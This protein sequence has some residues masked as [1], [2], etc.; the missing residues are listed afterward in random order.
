[1]FNSTLQFIKKAK[2]ITPQKYH[3]YLNNYQSYIE[4]RISTMTVIK[5]F[6]EKKYLA[7]FLYVLKSAFLHPLRTA[8]QALWVLKN[9]LLSKV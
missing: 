2:N 4:R 8:N 6:K 3:Q 1:M 7:L 5:L 9:K